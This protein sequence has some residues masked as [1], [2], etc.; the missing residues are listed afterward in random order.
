MMCGARFLCGVVLALWF[1]QSWAQRAGESAVTEAEDAFGVRV[2]NESI[3]LYGAYDARGFSPVQAGNVRIEGLYFDQQSQPNNRVVRGS[4]VHVGISAQSYPFPAP[5]GVADY[6]L[7]LPGDKPLVSNVLTYGNYDTI[8]VELDGQV[9]VNDKLSLGL[10]AGIVRYDNDNASKNFEWNAGLLFRARPSDNAEISGFWS[11]LEDC[12]NEQQMQIY[13]GGLYEPPRYQRRVYYG[14]GWSQGDCRESSG[15]VLGR[16]VLPDDWT[17]RG[18]AFRSESIQHR[19]YG[20]YLRNV[21][22]DGSGQHMIQ[23]FPRQAFT[24][25]SGELRATKLFSENHRRHTIDVSLRARDVQRTF[26]GTDTVS[27]GTGYVG[28]KSRLPEPVFHLGPQTNDHTKQ[29][30]VGLS[31]DGLWAGV[32]ALGFGVQKVLYHRDTQ[33]PNVPLAVSKSQP[34]LYNGTLNVLLNKQVAAYASFTRGLEES[35]T[36]PFSAVNGGEAMPAALTRQIDAGLRYAITPR[37]NFVAGVFQVEKPYFSLNAAN[38]FGPSGQVRHRG[39]ELSLAGRVIEGLTVVGG[40]VL[41]Q[42]R[43]SGDAVDRG[44]VGRIPLGPRERFALITLQYQPVSWGGLGIDGQVTNNSGQVARTDNRLRVGGITQLN[45]GARYNFKLADV[46]ASLRAQMQNVTN[47]F[48]WNVS[49]SG[50]FSPRSPRRFYVT[51]AAD[52]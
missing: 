52:F 28:V 32:G 45:L 22:P 12:H 43:V 39:I 35:G 36:A 47:A 2:G 51:L 3:G 41:L 10:G 19:G 37:L 18:G 17:V 20:D 6:I 44:I 25:Y 34:W 21:Q 8:I 26:G 46:P 5:T 29:G 4:A 9:P 16:F 23:R 40:A 48:A 31:Y 30:T 11:Q 50:S 49:N 38:V 13:S 14:Q 33:Q 1:G 27:L 15:G 7:R 42:P 24:S